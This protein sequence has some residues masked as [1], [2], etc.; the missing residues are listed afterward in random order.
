MKIEKKPMPDE[1]TSNNAKL[2]AAVLA[3]GSIGGLGGHTIGS[4]PTAVTDSTIHSCMEFSKHARSHER[5]DCEREKILIKM[6][7]QHDNK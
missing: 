1:A 2:A 5:S 4:D 6:G 3:A 7:C